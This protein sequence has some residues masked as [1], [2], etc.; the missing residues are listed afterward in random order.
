MTTTDFAEQVAG[1][2][3]R[4]AANLP[5]KIADGLAALENMS[6][7]AAEAVET[8][9]VSHRRLHEMCGL[10]PTLGFAGIGTA[11]RAAEVVV[12]EAASAKRAATPAEIA[13]LKTEL[14]R[15]HLAATAELKNFRGKV[16]A[17]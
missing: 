3:A 11:A 10:A 14:E 7:G 6:G 4:F 12:R 1:V 9:I 8:V 5:G 17:P 16:K 2:C 15:L 13:A